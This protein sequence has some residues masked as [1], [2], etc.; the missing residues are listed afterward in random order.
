MAAVSTRRLQKEL[1]DIKT[2]GTPTGTSHHIPIVPTI[3]SSSQQ[4]EVFALKFRFE[5]GYPISAPAVQFVVDQQY[6]APLHPVSTPQTPLDFPHIL[7]SLTRIS[8]STP[9]AM[10]A[11]RSAPPPEPVIDP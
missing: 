4:G 11:P 9:M 8:M 7:T 3:T 10:Y 6:K 1:T 2:H 5:P